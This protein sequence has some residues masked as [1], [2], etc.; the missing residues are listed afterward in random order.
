M[1]LLIITS[2][3][4]FIIALN[5]FSQTITIVDNEDLNQI[6]DVAILNE[7]KSKFIYTN[8]SGKADISSFTENEIICFQHFTYESICLSL[9][10]IKKMGY[11]IHLTKKIFA[12]E[13][14]V[15]SANRWEQNR[16]EVPNK[17]STIL[18]PSVELQN[19]QTAADLLGISDEVFIQKSQLGGGSPMIR[20]FATNRVLIIVDGVRMN[21]AIYREGNIQNVIS[22]DPSAL[23]STEIIFGPGATVYGSDA[24]GGIMDFHTKKA[25]FTTGNNLYI[26]A[27]AFSRFATANKEKT[28]H[29]DI[30][31]GSRRI[32]FLTSITYSDFEDLRMG[33]K[34]NPGYLRPEYVL[35]SGGMDSVVT[36]PNP[37]I[38]V[39]S[40]YKQINALNKLRIKLSENID[41][42]YANHF[43]ELSDV[44]RY[45]KLIQYRFGNLRYAEWYYGPQVWMMN[46][47]QVTIKKSNK[48]FD[49]VTLTAAQQ[50][51]KE[52]RHER[53]FGNT[54]INEQ[55]DKVSIVSLNLDFDKKLKRENQFIYYGF[56]YVNN[57][58][59][60][61]AHIRNSITG[62]LTPAA[63]RYPDG[64]NRY[65]STSIYAGYKNNISEKI[66][67]NTGIRFNQITLYSTITDN[68]FFNVPF[69]TISMSNG[70]V[71]G[72]A[73][74]VLKPMEKMQI[75]FNTSTGFRAPNLD[76]VG[77]IFDPVAGIVVVPNP[78]LKPEYAYNIDLGISKDFS[79]LLHVDITLFYTWL[80]NAM[81]RHD[82]LFNGEDSMMYKNILSKVQAITNTS[83]A[84]VSGIHINL[85]ANITD[86]LSIRSALNITKGKEKGD[87]PLR[88][89]APLFGSTHL[90]YK[91]SKLTADLYSSYN[92]SRKYKDMPPS[93]TDKPYLYAADKDGNPWSP[94]WFTFNLKASFNIIK[95]AII[96]GGIE[97]ILDHRYRPYSSGIVAPGRNFIISLRI[98][99]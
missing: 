2:I 34:K 58:I 5:C 70:A 83:Y 77:K 9:E 88:H 25:L 52:S 78:D 89:A 3:L 12:F 44:P 26:K 16:N 65:Q 4:T 94:G 27:D 32:A 19:P 67:L 24:I 45:D 31:I 60:S 8:R 82:F 53:S 39:Y 1:R 61:V 69:T 99:I 87:I 48:L 71:T 11:V 74:I 63:S 41:I 79:D 13:E 30:N 42:V 66:T 21:N 37:E 36:N 93:E 17:I 86:Y 51:Y 20:G 84:K 80:D 28:N 49:E 7:A 18:K 62:D 15:I 76:D 91:S 68:T 14:F 46:S 85:Q 72:A 97:N 59:K 47:I 33:S 96:N 6:P 64:K 90:I 29:F 40:G 50:N 38:Q 57:D 98:I 55:F 10:E 23:E 56:E 54:S 73:G 81:T 22:L 43:S 95:W 92:G 35:P 75:N